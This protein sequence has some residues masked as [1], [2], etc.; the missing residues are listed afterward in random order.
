METISSNL[1]YAIVTIG[2][3]KGYKNVQAPVKLTT[4][5]MI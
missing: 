5:E 3:R 2:L 1:Y 4:P